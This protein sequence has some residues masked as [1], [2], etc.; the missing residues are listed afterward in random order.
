MSDLPH[1]M[2]ALVLNAPDALSLDMRPVPRPG[3]GEVLVRLAASPVNPSDLMTLKGQYGIT[4]P[5]P[6]IPGLEAAGTVVAAAPGLMGRYLMGRKVACASGQ[7]GMWAEYAVVPVTA[8]VPLPKQVPLGAGAMS[9]VNPLTAIALISLAR[10]GGHWSA[11]ST[12]AGGQLGRMIRRRARD[13]GLKIIN[14]VRKQAQVEALRAEGARYVLN[15]TA[16][17]FDAELA[18]LCKTLRC[19]MAFDA[20]GG[21]MTYRLTEALRPQAEILVYGALAEK[22][23]SVHPGTLIFKEVTIRG[24]WLSKWLPR[25]TL[26][27]ILLHMRAATN[28]LR[29]GFAESTVARI[30]PL[31]EAEAA[32]AAYASGMS[33]G[34]TLLRLG[35]DDLGVT[36]P[37][38][39]TA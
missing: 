14:V 28:G 8:C 9:A 27:E 16:P 4:A 19:R 13:K 39:G 21:A 29:D 36:V 6:L 23:V 2:R 15:E 34:K 22:A 5:Y 7:G 35:P 1:Q 24:F 33:A 10:R 17:D 30:A 37:G 26:P 11:I 18:D 32:I 3:P 25:K 31:D 12:A 20:V 38:G